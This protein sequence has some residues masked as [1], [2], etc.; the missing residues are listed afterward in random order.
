LIVESLPFESTLNLEP[1]AKVPAARPAPQSPNTL[2]ELLKNRVVLIGAAAG[3]ACLVLLLVFAAFKRR[4]PERSKDRVNVPRAIEEAEPGGP[5]FAALKEAVRAAAVE[6]DN[7]QDAMPAL[8]AASKAAPRINPL[9]PFL[10]R[11]REKV[12]TDT[13]TPVNLLRTWVSEAEQ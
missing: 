6:G 7:L 11:V 2:Q 12:K 13:R 8:A 4:S 9:D 1:P 10:T 3:A 5:D